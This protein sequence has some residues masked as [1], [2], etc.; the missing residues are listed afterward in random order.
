MEVMQL[1]PQWM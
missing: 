1:Y